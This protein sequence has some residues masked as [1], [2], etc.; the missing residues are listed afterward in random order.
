MS[1]R[2]WHAAPVN[3]ALTILTMTFEE[4]LGTFTPEEIDRLVELYAETINGYIGLTN[5]CVLFLKKRKV[6]SERYID[7]VLDEQERF[8]TLVKIFEKQQKI[9]VK[10]QKDNIRF[11]EFGL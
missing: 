9:A 1:W 7:L 2:E 10:I 11:K 6:L 5:L 3:R 4:E 8:N